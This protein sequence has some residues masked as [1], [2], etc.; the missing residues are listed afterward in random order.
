VK[1]L[2]RRETVLACL[3]FV[4]GLV[5]YVRTLAPSV[6]L[7]DSSEF[8]VLAYTL[9]IAHNTGYPIYLL[10][11]KLFTFLPV[12]DVAYRVNLLSAVSAAAALVEVYLIGFLL[13]GRRYLSLLGPLLLAINALFWWQAVI[14]EVYTPAA[15]FTGGVLLFVLLYG[16]NAR[17]RNLFIA[18]LL[19]G[20]SLGVH[21]LTALAAPAVLLYLLVKKANRQSWR[22]ALLGGLIGFLL[23]ALSFVMLDAY[24][25]PTSMTANFRIHAS[26]YGLQPE[27]FDSAWT[28]ISFI[29]FSRQWRGQMFSGTSQDVN[30]NLDVYLNR[31]WSTFGMAFNFLILIGTIGLFTPRSDL[32]GRWKEGLLLMG[33]WLAM[34]IFL[35]NYRVGDLEVFFIPLYVILAAF[36]TVGASQVVAG[37]MSFLRAL[38]LDKPLARGLVG[39]VLASLCL[40]SAWTYL[41]PVEKSIRQGRIAFLD[42]SRLYYPYPVLDPGYPLR[43]GRRIASLVEDDAILFIDWNMLYAACYAAHVEQKRSGIACYE[44]MPFGTNERFADSAL[45]FVRQNVDQRPIYFSVIPENLKGLYRFRQVGFTYP[46]YRLM[47][48]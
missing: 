27:D 28:R 1:P 15:A 21:T 23:F 35:V 12:G 47:K 43:E 4:L 33:S 3:V 20:L 24:G 9:G 39:L 37:I 45:E 46:L 42:E 7:G 8:Q 6:L 10:I 14:A 5:L 38:H 11:G 31:T 19:G 40:W 26:A 48:K 32:P 34:M 18:G 36:L 25:H 44:P 30:N 17:P 2:S 13:S 29:F 41:Q 16:Q 22:A